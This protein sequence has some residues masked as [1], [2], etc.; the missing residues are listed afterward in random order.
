[1]RDKTRNNDP[2]M[3]AN[4]GEPDPFRYF[5][6]SKTPA[7]SMAIAASN[8]SMRHNWIACQSTRVVALNTKPVK[9]AA[10][11]QA[12]PKTSAT[13]DEVV[14]PSHRRNAASS[15]QFAIPP[16]LVSKLALV[17]WQSA[18][19][20]GQKLEPPASDAP[21]CPQAVVE[22][23]PAGAT[24]SRGATAGFQN[25]CRSWTSGAIRLGAGFAMRVLLPSPS[26][27]KR[28]THDAILLC[29]VSGC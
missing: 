22:A 8:H 29:L 7:S 24:S 18:P 13:K 2:P 25:S 14:R 9:T 12:H 1:M 20:A 17:A 10:T 6:L 19:Q 11:M 5:F 21:Q 4:W 26:A 28:G 23:S 27:C 16:V 3:P 15:G